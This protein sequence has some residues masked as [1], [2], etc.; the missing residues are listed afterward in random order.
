MD[1]DRDKLY[2][3]LDSMPERQIRAS[4]DHGWDSVEKRKIAEEYLI[5]K[6]AERQKRMNADALG[7]AKSGTDAAWEGAKAALESAKAARGANRLA[8]VAIVLS[9]IALL[10]A[11]RHVI[12]AALKALTS[13]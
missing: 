10:Y 6:E 5:E 9:V 2:Q 12:E 1:V 8:T 11:A 13:H 7:I 3:E 4:I